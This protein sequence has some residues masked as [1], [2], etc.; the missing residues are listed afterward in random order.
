MSISAIQNQTSIVYPTPAQQSISEADKVSSTNIPEQIDSVKLS[1][2]S[3]AAQRQ[4][5]YAL[6]TDPAQMYRDW[7]EMPEPR[8]ISLPGPKDYDSLLPETQTYIDQ[9]EVRM[10][11]ASSAE[12]RIKLDG[13]ISFASRYGDKEMIQSD[14]DAFLRMR[15]SEVATSLKIHHFAI[16]NEEMSLPEGVRGPESLP[17]PKLLT[18][19]DM[20]EY[21]KMVGISR[22][23]T[24]AEYKAIQEQERKTIESFYYGWLNGSKAIYSDPAFKGL[25]EENT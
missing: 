7:L 22:E 12:E 9:L 3:L 21:N 10:E 25:V 15:V 11:N 8:Y 6:K 1:E 5:K 23:Q 13:L 14:Q 18:L 20:I 2:E 4:E 16:H 19:E 17:G 24:I